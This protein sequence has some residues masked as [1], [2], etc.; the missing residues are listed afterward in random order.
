MSNAQT[1][2]H[3]LN[4]HGVIVWQEDGQLRYKAPIGVM[5]PD[6]L[7]TIRQHKPH[8]MTLLA[9]NDRNKATA[10][11]ATHI[12]L[13]FELDGGRV[14]C[15]DPISQSLGEAVTTLRQRFQGRVGK[16]WQHDVE[17]TI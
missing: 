7:T 4:D 13:T 17:V 16:I 3:D 11:K 1:L 8:L 9:S 15:L 6:L 2:L 10:P 14:T 5:T 12:V